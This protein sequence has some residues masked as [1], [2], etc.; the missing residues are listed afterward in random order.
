MLNKSCKINFVNENDFIRLVY[1]YTAIDMLVY[2]Y[3]YIYIY[4]QDGAKVGLQFMW[5]VIQ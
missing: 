4:I 3:I 1:K 2:I 5:K